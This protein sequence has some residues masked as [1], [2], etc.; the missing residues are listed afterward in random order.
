MKSI[1]TKQD[2]RF[3]IET[4]VE[5]FPYRTLWYVLI[6]DDKQFISIVDDDPEVWK[7]MLEV[8]KRLNP[9]AN[10]TKGDAG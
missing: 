6:R 5:V 2:G 1:T 4:R 10:E 9:T 8:F 3:I 7:A